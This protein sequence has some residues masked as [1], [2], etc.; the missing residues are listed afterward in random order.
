M[1][2]HR[3]MFKILDSIGKNMTFNYFTIK[4]KYLEI[5]SLFLLKLFTKFNVNYCDEW[6]TN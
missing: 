6:I 3:N 2:V 1:Y 5:Y 4:K